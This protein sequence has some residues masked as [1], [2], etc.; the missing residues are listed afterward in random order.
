MAKRALYWREISLVPS[1]DEIPIVVLVQEDL[2]RSEARTSVMACVTTNGAALS[3]KIMAHI[4]SVGGD[5]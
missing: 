4:V 3:A 1:A 2:E 5:N